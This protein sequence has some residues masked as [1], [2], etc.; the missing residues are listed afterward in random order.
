ML[1]F[2]F[3]E[4]CKTELIAFSIL[5]LFFSVGRRT[6]P[7]CPKPPPGFGKKKDED[8]SAGS[9]KKSSS[10]SHGTKSWTK[11][12]YTWAGGKDFPQFDP[13]NFAK[14][15]AG[16]NSRQFNQHANMNYNKHLF[17]TTH[18]NVRGQVINIEGDQ[19]I[20]AG[21][22]YNLPGNV[23]IHRERTYMKPYTKK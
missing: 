7:K 6:K 17:K 10:S 23:H 20:V 22:V 16:A 3:F 2:L 21:N 12:K 8:S 14:F 9:S 18:L 13:G 4:V 11:T 1:T 15:T 19:T 5:F